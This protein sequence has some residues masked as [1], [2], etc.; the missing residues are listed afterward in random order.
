MNARAKLGGD[1]AFLPELSLQQGVLQAVNRAFALNRAGCN[2]WTNGR[3]VKIFQFWSQ[4]FTLIFAAII[5]GFPADC[6]QN[7]RTPH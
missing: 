6:W 1:H 7:L 4:N 2:D 5:L 3:V